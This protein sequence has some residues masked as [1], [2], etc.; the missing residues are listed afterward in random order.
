MAGGVYCPLSPRDPQ[1]RLHA[2][3]QQT[4][5]RLVL[6]HYLTNTKF[7]RDIVLLDTDS[8]LNVYNMD[9]DM[10]YNYLSSVTVKGKEIAYVI[11]TSGSTGTP[12]AVQVRH[13]NFIDCINSLVYINS[14]NQ[15]DTVVQMTRCS[16]D[17]HVQ[18]ILGTL[19]IG[20]TLI[21][22]RPEDKRSVSIGKPLSNYRCMI[23]NQHLQS[24]VTDEEAELFVGGVGVF[25][26]YLEREDLAAKALVE[27]DCELFYRT[28]DIV[29]MDSNGLIHYHGRKD[30]Q[31]KLH[32]QRIELGEIE[33][34]LLNITSISACVV[35]KWNDDYLVAYVQ[36][37]H[38][39]EE[40]LRQHCQ[41]HL[42]PHMVPSIFIVCDKLPLNQNGKIDRKQ[43]P[44][45][46]FTHLSL[47]HGKHNT[48]LLLPTND[49]EV[50][51]HRIWCET[52]K[53]NR[54]SIDTNI[55]T[56]GGH[57]LFMMQ[58]FHRYKIE[59]ELET[60]ALSITDLFQHPT[61]LDHAQLIYQTITVTENITDHQWSSL[62]I[63][64][65][66]ASFAQER[67]FLDE[68]I[69][70]SSS[71][72]SNM[73]D[74]PLMY[75]VSSTN[76]YIT[77]SRLQ[78]AFQSIIRKHQV[79][80]TSL[81]L[82]INGTIIQH[83]LDANVI[84][85]DKNF[86]R[87][88]MINLSD[89]EH[90]QNEIV[91]KILNQ[92]DLFDLSIGHV[93]NCHILR[94]SQFNHSFTE[95]NDL[96]SKDDLIL[97]TIHHACFDGTSTSIFL[98][99]LSLAYQSND[100]LPIDDS[101]LQYIDYSIHEHIMDMKLSQEF[102][103]SE[104]KGYNLARQLSL[105]IERQRS[106]TNQQRSGL[107]CSAQITFDDEICASFLNYASSHHLTL[108]QLGLSIFYV[109]LFKLTYGESDLC[110]SSINANRYRSELVN[111]IGMFVSTLPYRVELDPYWS[112][113]E[114][115]KYVQEKCL[116]ILEHSH[117]PLQNILGDLHL[118]QS[119]VSF[120]ETIFDFI[121]ISK[122]VNG[123][124]LNGVNLEQ[125]WLKESYDMAKF[126]FSLT[127]V[128][129][130][131]SNDNQLS[132]S[133][134]CSRDLFD[135]R[136]VLTLSQ[137]FK[138]LCEQVFSSKLIEKPDDTCSIT[139]AQLNLILLDELKEMRDF[140][141][142]RQ[143]NITNEDA[144]IEQ[145]LLMSGAKMFWL[146]NLHDCKLDQS[147]PLPYDRYRLANEHRT[148]RG[149]S[150][151]FD[152]GQ[153]LSQYM[154]IYAS[155]NNIS[156]EHLTFAIYF[157]FLFQLTN[158]QTDL[159]IGM[160]I[161]NRYRD[162]LNFQHNLDM[163]ELSYTINGSLDLFN[164]ETVI[165]TAQ[166]FHSML[167]HL[168]ISVDNQMNKSIYELSLTLPNER[169]LMQSI[170][171]T[172]VSFL[173]PVT[174]IHH[175]FIYQVMKHPQKLAVELD[176]QSLSYSE[177]LYYVQMLSVHILDE[178]G[179]IPGKVIS[180]C[181]ERSL[182]MVIGIMAIE[183]TSSVYCPLS[184]RDPQ[185]RLHA[186]VKQTQ[187]RLVLVHW[188]TRNKFNDDIP[189]FDI[190]S[191]LTYKDVI[192]DIDADR[193]SNVTVTV[194]DI[195][196]IIF[197]SGSTGI[198][199]PAQLRHRN[200]TQS[201]RSLVLADVFNKSD[202]VVQIARC[203]FDIHV[204]EIVGTIIIGACLVMLHPRGN[205]DFEYLS[206]V[207][208]TKQ[209]SFLYTVPT[210]LQLFFDFIVESK[211]SFMVKCL[212][213]LCTGGERCSLK[214]IQLLESTTENCHIWNLCGPA[215][216]TLQSLFH[217]V[218]SMN[219]GQSIPLGM[220][221]PNYRCIAQDNFDQPQTVHS[222]GELLVSGVGIFAGYLGRD[223]LSA[224]AFIYINNDLF[225]RTG[226]LVH[227]NN[228]GLIHYVGRKDH[229]IKLHGQRIELGEIEQC[230]LRT[231]IS[232]CVVIKWN[233][234]YLVAYVQSSDI[235]ENVLREHCQSHL[236]P[237]MIPSFFII[238]EKLPLNPNGKVDRK[239]LPLP[240]FS[241]IR[242]TNSNELLLPMNETE[243][244]IHHI[245]CDILKQK[246]ISTDTNIFSIGGH[247]LLIMQL[248]HRYKTH[249]HLKANSLSITDLFQ[250]PTILDHAQLIYQTMTI[251]E[252]FT[253][254]HWSPL[255]I[256]EAK[257]SF[258][259]ERIFLDEQIRFSSTGNNTNIYVIPL[260]YRISSI[261]DHISISRLQYAFQSI[262]RKHQIL[263]TSL[264]LDMNGVIVQ[265][266]LDTNVI[267]DDKK[268]SEFSM[269]NLPNEEHEQN[270]I[271][272]KILN[273]SDLFDLSTGHV[274]NCH[275]LR[276]DQSNHSFTQN[277]D[278]LTKD[279]LILFTIHHA[280]FDGASTSIFIRDLSLAYQS[281]G[282]LPVHDNSLQYID[283]S[284]H[285]HIMNMTS[286][287]EF[288]LLELKQ[289]NFTHHLSLPI[290]RQRSATDQRSGFASIA[291]ITFDDEICASFLNYASS[292]H[293]TL[294]QLGLSIF[295][296][297]LFKLTHGETDL[298]ISSINANRYRSEL[299]DMIG[300]FVSTLPYRVELDSRWLFEKVVKY[301]QEKCLS[302]L[303]HSHYPLQHI[304]ADLHLTQSSLSFL[305]T[306][307]DF[308]S[309]SKDVSELRLNGVNLE[310]IL[311]QESYEM[312][313][314][315]FSLT[316]VYNS[317]SD[318]NQLSCSFVGSS[319]LFNERTVSILSQRFK[320]L[321]EQVFSSKLIEK[322]DDT[323]SI[324]IAQLNLILLDELKEMQDIV[325]SRQRHIINEAP[326]SFAQAGIWH[327]ERIRFDPDQSQVTVYNM[328]FVY[329]A[330]SRHPISIN[331]LHNALEVVVAKHQSLRTSLTFDREYH[332]LTQKIIDFNHQN[333]TLFTFIKNIYE[334]DEQL[335]N[336]INE[337]KHSSQLFNL[338][339]G[340][341]F[342]CHLLHYKEISL[343][344]LLSDKDVI[345]FNFH[346]AS[347]DFASM[348]I[349]LRD[350]NQAYATGQLPFD[351]ENTTLR[352]LDY[353]VI[354]QQLLMSGAKMFWLDNLHDCKLDQS[355]PLPYDRYRLAS[356][357]RTHC[358][359]SIS[360]DFGQD[361]SQ[362][363][364]TYASSNNISLEYLTLAIYFIFLFKLTNGEKDLCIGMTID[365]RYRDELKSIIGLFENVI[366]LRCRLDPHW[367]C[368][369]LYEYVHEIAKN[370]MNY[371]YFP[372]QRILQQH[373][374][375]SKPTF[376]DI[377]FEC[378]SSMTKN[379]TN[380]IILDDN[381]LS[382][383]PFSSKISENEIMSNF[384]FIASFQHNLDMNELSYTINGS[385]DLFNT[386]TVTKTAYRFHSMINQLFISMD[387]QMN[388][389]IYEISLTLSTEQLLL[390]SMNNTQ[391]SFSSPVTCI[392]HEF[393]YQVMKHPQKLAVELDD[394]SLTYSELL[395]YVQLLSLNLLNEYHVSLGDVICQCVERSLS[396]VIGIMAIEM[397]GGVYCPL[398]PRDPPHRLQALTQQTQSRLVFIHWLTRKLFDDDITTF[399]ISSALVNN[400]MYSCVDI[401]QLSS[402]K[403]R[404]ENVA[405]II[406]TSGS[407]GIPKAVQVQHKNFT[408]FMDSLIYGDVLNE[409]DT[410]LQMARC[411]F[412]VHVQD[413]LGT[414]MTGSSLIMLHPRGIIDF[415]YLAS[416]MK[417]KCIT[418]I[419]TVPTII[420]NFFTFL[421]QQNHHNVAQYLRSVC[422][423]GM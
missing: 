305:E 151:S 207:L 15:D 357:H 51:I 172:Q 158:G 147:L 65:A 146:D 355:L 330:H 176:D 67:I 209:T 412:D 245:W 395:Y 272:K 58:L 121:S 45:P 225:Y 74:I 390:Q 204:Q 403:V 277:N 394:Q 55:F 187:S 132:C 135:E 56:I 10:N 387:S 184:P 97:F 122:D 385:L 131:S 17:I 28:G 258:A 84:I 148:Y 415:D 107:A 288:W 325:F 341:V 337:E 404:Q 175:E 334:T 254:Y 401:E 364:I 94:H 253:D 99:D 262:I 117:Y 338:A 409:N 124:C 239:L 396:M 31:V 119:N 200:F 169:L 201:I 29:R 259:Q 377:S 129:N 294:F 378:I 356:D 64:Q 70:F 267:I 40:Q 194:D 168:F 66:K 183:M 30:H 145:Q 9:S 418:C 109:F 190:D 116:S 156:L 52:L 208:H 339:Q 218:N 386:E 155:S 252:N 306:M 212:R 38:I 326:A 216:T 221:L 164:T 249:F 96:L 188:L 324:T 336:I 354:E 340:H 281:D 112:F 282:S 322:P 269:I 237:H 290:D 103:L 271:V 236:P 46:T 411:S 177:L 134:V 292:H 323:C 398:S 381:Q 14:F 246:Q 137:R 238:L 76:D 26:G 73:Y 219:D 110:I 314:F 114:V 91:K 251:T 140:V 62:H 422:S 234:D 344:D 82:D 181:V 85:D 43:L 229:Q 198:P 185:T 243:I 373:P 332:T 115:V 224:K 393:V 79:L 420:N 157:I 106:S 126:D 278:L 264:Y 23:M 400:D 150:V 297:F 315:D 423:G 300:M 226:D 250:H 189:S 196:Y 302:I 248:F 371:S 179:I 152:F 345:I 170:N 174:C 128:Y 273:Q 268:S 313:K 165:K 142:C 6:I 69:R 192:C 349:F 130:P 397:A 141:F 171:N 382:L 206:Q 68:Q 210:L 319:E 276:R 4:Q 311:L 416:V 368:H 352:Y 100:F 222:D 182:S 27:I 161:D 199:K 81:Y 32:G 20:G 19:L 255:H 317:T 321:C 347:F 284:V 61:I 327:D 133:F 265:N 48:E 274:I 71:N 154:I 63:M 419:T 421:Q 211:K 37:S 16:F 402:V 310:Q 144:V 391:I 163:N 223:D 329:H 22:L 166:G 375:V 374:K 320:Y 113:D 101:S 78:Y 88:P 242:L 299:V 36:S 33:R 417:E 372:L 333:N 406:F 75:R 263:R 215:E 136:T 191:I 408:R 287:Q 213:S 186:L 256:I 414:L 369:Q 44:S 18:E 380:E 153:D 105:P 230:L 350:L 202:I 233:D 95:N 1:H 205:T 3:T 247:S 12:K 8:V 407:T 291:Q 214:L 77:I 102:W 195:A 217:Q 53:Q 160:T 359:T 351:D 35:M 220:P 331:Q 34:C 87:F 308:I 149:T 389:P 86:S 343:N 405:Y 353:A 49:I 363:L 118:T 392:H 346:H 123:L 231:S 342:R 180:Q 108:F 13:Q 366:P 399:D 90:A 285:E 304:L 24:S 41:S 360:F 2:L 280:S 362:Y 42:P 159:C 80:R 83:C 296:V 7:D 279:D 235:D 193:L 370:T 257:A 21:M 227:M 348:N 57:S 289:Y 5:S 98:R 384:D 11:F 286:S 309:I 241:S 283:Y 295:Y 104:L 178:C 203:S 293:L 270:G 120:L 303:E 39:N 318:A 244:I 367:S 89:E 173:S 413:I 275:I 376:L 232:A 301:V 266:C 307:F 260:I 60:K 361:L 316:F 162:E 228:K 358:G 139:I 240:N 312:A 143:K 379:N 388:K 261:N 383:I 59:F 111:M 54:I 93:I 298:C 197:T 72:N 138:H 410:I 125:V 328:P 167:N 365:N 47:N 25:A 127:F 335:N 50:S 92:S